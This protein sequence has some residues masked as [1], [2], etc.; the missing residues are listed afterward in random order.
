VITSVIG[1][2][3]ERTVGGVRMDHLICFV[4]PSAIGVGVACF[5]YNNSVR[6]C[7]LVDDKLMP[8]CWTAAASICGCFDELRCACARTGG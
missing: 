4:P 8:D 1:P 6:I 3:E 7:F 2:A 5:S